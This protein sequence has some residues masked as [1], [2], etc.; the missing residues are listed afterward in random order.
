MSTITATRP[1]SALLGMH[2]VTVDEYERIIASGSLDDPERVEL[3]DGYMVD[4]MAKSAEH[5]FSTR[6]VLDS[7]EYRLPGGWSSRKEEPVR[8]P[9]FDEP[10]PDVS[11]VRGRDEDYEHRLPGPDDVGLAV[12]VSLTTLDRDRDEKGPAYARARIPIYWLVNLVDRRI[13]VYT[14]PGPDGYQSRADF[15][16]GQAVP[17]EIGGQAVDALDVRSVLPLWPA[18]SVVEGTVA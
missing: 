7:L 1:R 18:G 4:K 2:R 3:I 8:I 12:E 16:E 11:V 10:E 15:A 9:D 5:G 6:R 13:E 14:E 17:V